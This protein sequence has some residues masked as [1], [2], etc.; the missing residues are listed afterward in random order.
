MKT[1]LLPINVEPG[2]DGYWFAEVPMLPG[3]AL[4]C[5]PLE[6]V[7][8]SIQDAAQGMLEIMVEHGDPLPEGIE[9]YEVGH[10]GIENT[11]GEVVRVSI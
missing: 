5:Y 1:Y 11:N 2:E 6:H 4:S 10:N 3:C 8:E 9:V 7:L